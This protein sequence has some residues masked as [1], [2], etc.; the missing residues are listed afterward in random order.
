MFCG[1]STTYAETHHGTICSTSKVISIENKQL[2]FSDKVSNTTLI[3][4]VDFD[5]EE[6][7]ASSHNAKE[8]SKYKIL[9][10]KETLL[11]RWY[12]PFTDSFVFQYNNTK[13]SITSEPISGYSSPIYIKNRVLRI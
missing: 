10:A 3:V 11:K 7:F 4:D 9:L 6:D 8:D 2:H 13:R 1:G 5:L 12:A